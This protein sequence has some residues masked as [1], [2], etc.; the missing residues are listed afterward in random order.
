[1]KTP[2]LIKTFAVCALITGSTHAESDERGGQSEP[3]PAELPA[4]GKAAEWVAKG[5]AL[6]QDARNK[7]SHDFTKAE[8]CYL[9]AIKLNPES[10]DAML[11]MAWVKNSQHLFEQGRGWAEK[12]LAFAPKLVDAHCLLGDYALE[13]GS[14]DEAFDHYQI[15]I[16]EKPDL[17]TYSRAAHLLW[18]TGD[19][20]TAQ[21]LMEKAI[22]AGGPFPENLAWCRVELGLMQF[23]I[24]SILSAEM[25][26]KQ[27]LVLSPDNPRALAMTGMLLASKGEFRKALEYMKCPSP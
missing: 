2:Y 24:G 11:G 17:S 5:D 9:E 25:Q 1:M 8:S 16:D 19:S 6:M 23:R 10:T 7:V 20:A 18:E 3:T 22:S 26:A 4:N 21:V 27:A 12:A 14:Y 15:A 13:L